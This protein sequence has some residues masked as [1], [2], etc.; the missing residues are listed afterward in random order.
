MLIALLLAVI[1]WLTSESF[2]MAEERGWRITSDAIEYKTHNTRISFDGY[3]QTDGFLPLRPNE[4]QEDGR[5]RRVRPTVRG[6]I[7][8]HISFKLMSEY[9]NGRNEL[10]DAYVTYTFDPDVSLTAGKMK[11]PVGLEINQSG[12]NLP[13]IER[14]PVST[15]LPIREYGLMSEGTIIDEKLHYSAGVFSSG[16]EN[17]GPD[18]EDWRNS[19]VAARLL[20]SPFKHSGSTFKK[21]EIG[22]GGDYGSRDSTFTRNRLTT[23][24]TSVRNPMLDYYSSVLAEGSM[25][26]LSPQFH[27][28]RGPFRLMGEHA[29][30]SQGTANR[31]TG[32]Y[33]R[34]IFHAAQLNTGYILTGEEARYDNIKPAKPFSLQ[35][36]DWG[37]FEITGRI[38]YIGTSDSL[39]ARFVDLSA[40]AGR[41]F[42]AT[43]GLNWYVNDYAKI[44]LNYEYAGFNRNLPEEQSIFTRL[45]LEF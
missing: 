39:D 30:I 35:S 44:M 36:S 9:G 5:F 4:A 43:A 7:G 21:L 37:A 24:R 25:W 6:E 31:A 42:A 33:S 11:M 3:M 29:F 15:L 20:Y 40:S 2:A 22:I 28:Y 8:E 17:E 32:D 38:A 18:G 26:R 19:T 41:L 13:F 12:S 45:Q 34:F 10:Q 1:V 16:A 27:W 14:S 23:P